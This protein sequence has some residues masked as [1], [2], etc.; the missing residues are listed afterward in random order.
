MKT[1]ATVLIVEQNV[2]QTLEAADRGYVIESGGIVLA[3]EA[4]AL[5]DNDHVRKAYL[6]I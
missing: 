4:K 2:H 3:V 5:L 6:G 1:G